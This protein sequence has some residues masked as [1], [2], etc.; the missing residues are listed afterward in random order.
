LLNAQ[1]A[2]T[3]AQLDRLRLVLWG[4]NL[5]NQAVPMFMSEANNPGGYDEEIDLPPRT[6]GLR[7]EYTF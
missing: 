5:T 6:Y 4:R 7:V 1:A 2:Y 3:P